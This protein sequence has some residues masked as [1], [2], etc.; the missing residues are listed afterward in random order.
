MQQI[1]EFIPQRGVLTP[2]F[3]PGAKQLPPEAKLRAYGCQF[4]NVGPLAT[5]YQNLQVIPSWQAWAI[6]GINLLGGT[7]G[8]QLQIWHVGKGGQRQLNSISLPSPLVCGAAAK[9]QWLLE[10]ELFLANDSIRIQ[11]KNLSSTQ[12]D[13]IWIALWGG[14]V[15]VP[16]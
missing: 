6:V 11:V 1:L 15:V 14:D 9:P 10:P 8:F 16:E 13:S 7:N 5:A 3:L 12:N 4:L 2:I